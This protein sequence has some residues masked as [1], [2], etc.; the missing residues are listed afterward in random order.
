MDTGL[1]R[2]VWHD[3][4]FA[5]KYTDVDYLVFNDAAR[6]VAEG[7]IENVL[8]DRKLRDVCAGEGRLRFPPRSAHLPTHFRAL[9]ARV[10]RKDKHVAN[11]H[12]PMIAL[13]PLG[14]E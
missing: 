6:F 4:S 9:P 2:A 5:V 7:G 14:V 1:P 13:S 10:T 11:A 8:V 12:A 3:S